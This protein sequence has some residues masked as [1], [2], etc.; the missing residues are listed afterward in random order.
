VNEPL[1]TIAIPAF[2]RP[3]N[4]NRILKILISEPSDKFKVLISDD[5][6]NDGVKKLVADYQKRM[7][8]LHYDKNNN[9]LGF[10][11][12]VAKLYSSFRTRYI[13]FLCDDDQIHKGVVTDIV[14]SLEKY[15]PSVAI[16]NCNWQDS[17]GRVM[18]AGP[19]KD[20]VYTDLGAFDD[21]AALMRATF[22]SILVLESGYPI[23]TILTKPECKDNVFIQLTLVLQILSNNFRLV[24]VSC[25]IVYRD[26]GFKYG[27]FFKF[28]LLDPLKA[29][30]LLPHKFSQKKFVEWMIAQLPRAGLLFLSQ[31]AGLF[32][33]KGFPTFQTLK[34][35]VKYYSWL[36]AIVFLAR[37]LAFLVPPFVIRGIYLMCLVKIY[38][39]YANG[40]K[41]Y[42]RMINRT[43]QDSRN[44][45]FTEY[46]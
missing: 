40:Y 22:L 41:I 25:S 31:K 18:V 6:T 2:N 20:E 35:V 15:Q 42:S 8:N 23:D 44:T 39:G 11:L 17:Y 33:Y 7:T 28:V 19:K 43:V 4:L 45:G 14:S 27:E 21:Y 24:L 30:G 38:G 9:N 3:E 5:S 12:N 46:R 10:N 34:Q 32:L 26:V 1:L 29:I 13:W 37:V 16:F 36:S